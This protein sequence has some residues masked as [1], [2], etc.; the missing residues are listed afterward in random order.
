MHPGLEGRVA[1]LRQSGH[2]AAALCFPEVFSPEMCDAVLALAKGRLVY[3]SAQSRPIED[4]RSAATLWMPPS[5][6]T[7]FIKERLDYVLKHVN[8]RYGFE[9]ADVYE[10]F[11]V[12]EYRVGD[13]FDWHMDVSERQT[14]T[15][16]L[17]IS[18]Q[19]SHPEAYEGGGLEF[20]PMGE[21]PFSRGRGSVIVFPSY[22]CHRA[23][24]VTKGARSV[25]VAWAHGPTF[26]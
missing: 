7:D 20:M 21:L 24:R 3:Q 25:L 12:C 14:S 26:R 1:P 2:V 16:K 8:R 15:R 6:E 22:L 17:S 10:D 18:V 19:L 23:D 4:Y 11:L 13:G 5:K 9:L